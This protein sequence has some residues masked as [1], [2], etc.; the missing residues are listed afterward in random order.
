[1]DIVFFFKKLLLKQ[2]EM[3][4]LFGTIFSYE[5]IH[6]WCFSEYFRQQEGFSKNK[7][8]CVSVCVC[9]CVCERERERVL[10]VIKERFTQRTHR[11]VSNSFW[12]T[13]EL[14]GTEATQTIFASCTRFLL[15]LVFM[16]YFLEI[17]KNI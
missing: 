10:V 2:G 9:V 12:V 17:K 6:I 5:L 8:E 4:D 11:C 3:V 1:M 16:Y 13:T 14:C 7:L 15:V